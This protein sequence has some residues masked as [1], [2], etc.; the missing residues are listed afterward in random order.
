MIVFCELLCFRDFVAIQGFSQ[1]ARSSSLY[2]KCSILN[3][4]FSD[5]SQKKPTASV[6][7][8]WVNSD[9]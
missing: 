1:G 3:A 2:V 7:E 5:Q 6:A 4:I 9:E 8:G